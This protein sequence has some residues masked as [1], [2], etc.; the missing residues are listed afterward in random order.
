M[1]APFSYRQDPAVPPFPDDRPII[2]FDGHCALCS[3]FARF[4]LRHDKRATF[5]LMAG[6]SAL[7]QAIYRHLDLDPTNFDTY[8][9]L[10]QGQ[11]SY[12]SQ[13]TIRIFQLLGFPWSASVLLKGIP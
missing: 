3:G 12:R 10:D 7:G 8:I 4:I 9:L 5:R 2:I 11:P 13:G 1:R 6:Q